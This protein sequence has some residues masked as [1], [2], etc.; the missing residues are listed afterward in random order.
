MAKNWGFYGGI[1]GSKIKNVE[2][3]KFF[4]KAG[5]KSKRSHNRTEALMKLLKRVDNVFEGH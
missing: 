1:L 4:T 3:L 5:K 2:A